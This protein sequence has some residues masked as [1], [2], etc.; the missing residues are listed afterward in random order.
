MGVK[1]VLV[2]GLAIF[3]ADVARVVAAAV[4]ARKH[5]DH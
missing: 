1:P 5:R 4:P 3:M 2:A